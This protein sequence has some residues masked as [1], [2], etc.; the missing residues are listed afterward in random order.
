M[1]WQSTHEETAMTSLTDQ[2][3]AGFDGRAAGFDRDNRFFDENFAR[4]GE[5]VISPEVSGPRGS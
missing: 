2:L 1:I 3:L 5:S 4:T